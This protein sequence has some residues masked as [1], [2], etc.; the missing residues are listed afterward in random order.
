MPR[1]PTGYQP[2]IKQT[3]PQCGG[4]KDFY[5]VACRKCAVPGKPLEGKKGENH[6]AWKGGQRIDKDGYIRTYCPDH[7]WPRRSGYVHEHVRLMELHIGRRI[8][9]GEVVHH[10]NEK[11]QDN[12]LE[13]LELKTASRHSSDH[14]AADK[15]TYRRNPKTGRYVPKE[16]PHAS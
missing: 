8:R 16:V 15:H 3:C 7:P 13:N 12:R 11:K 2:R 6:P 9:R 4:M 14:R 10:R 5:A 1:W